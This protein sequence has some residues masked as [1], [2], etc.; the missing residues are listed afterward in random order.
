M[1]VKL[2]PKM[3][4][5]EVQKIGGPAGWTN[6]TVSQRSQ[7]ADVSMTKKTFLKR[8]GPW[9]FFRFQLQHL[10]E[11]IEIRLVSLVFSTNEN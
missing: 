5:K 3:A 11:F 7:N 8:M 6:D 2:P 4:P 10:D 9:D 1:V